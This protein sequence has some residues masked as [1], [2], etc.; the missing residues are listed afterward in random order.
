M[1]MTMLRPLWLLPLSPR[2]YQPYLPI[3]I[4]LPKSQ[5]S[6]MIIPPQLLV[7]AA[8]M[9]MA[10]A[11]VLEPAPEVVPVAVLAPAQVVVQEVARAAAPAQALEAI[12]ATILLA[13]GLAAVALVATVLITALEVAL[14]TVEGQIFLLELMVS[15]QIRLDS[16][17]LVQQVNSLPIPQD[18]SFQTLQLSSLPTLEVSNPPILE[19]ST[20]QAL[21]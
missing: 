11:L 21:Q 6:K 15:L 18:N 19:D 8:H 14:E 13:V 17:H 10:A 5:S 4:H 3:R 20:H 2:L 9:A 16:N 7:R 1:A 12:V